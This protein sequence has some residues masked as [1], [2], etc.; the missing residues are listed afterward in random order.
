MLAQVN[1]VENILLKT[2]STKTWASLKEPRTY[3][4]IT[5]NGRGNLINICTSCLTKRSNGINLTDTL[6]KEGVGR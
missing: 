5:A 3:A 1:E 6:S 2:A 4:S